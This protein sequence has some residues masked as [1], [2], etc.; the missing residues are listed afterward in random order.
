[1]TDRA[2]ALFFQRVQAAGDTGPTIAGPK[3]KIVLYFF[4]WSPDQ[5]PFADRA[6]LGGWVGKRPEHS[7][8]GLGWERFFYLDSL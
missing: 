5:E 1:M 3:P 8:D 7:E 4:P 2:F 6:A